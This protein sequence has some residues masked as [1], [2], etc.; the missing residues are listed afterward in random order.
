[1][2]RQ[3]LVSPTAS[4]KRNSIFIDIRLF[5]LELLLNVQQQAIR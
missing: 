5:T 1:M 4:H 3:K 2:L